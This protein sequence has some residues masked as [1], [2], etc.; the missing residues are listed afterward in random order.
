MDKNKTSGSDQHPG[1]PAL[2]KHIIEMPAIEKPE[3][4]KPPIELPDF[5]TDGS[6]IKSDLEI[7]ADSPDNDG[8]D[9][10]E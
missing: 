7:T 5:D 10:A 3:I 1:H 8:N 9:V 6:I 2:P 4:N